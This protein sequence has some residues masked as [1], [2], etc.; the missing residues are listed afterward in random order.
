MTYPVFRGEL[1]VQLLNQF[2]CLFLLEV[3]DGVKDLEGRERRRRIVREGR[4]RGR[5]DGGGG[6]WRE[7]GG[8][9]EGRKRKER[10]AKIQQS[11]VTI[12]V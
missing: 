5:E 10:Q 11:S 3:H 7:D 4:G 12:P 1:D 8:G 9:K 2:F 6:R